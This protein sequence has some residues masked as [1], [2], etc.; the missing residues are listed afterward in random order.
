MKVKQKDMPLVSVGC[1]AY[2]HEA[3][4]AQA[5]EGFLMQKTTFPVEIIVYDDASTD[6]TADI[7][8]DYANRYP[9]IIKPVLQNR[10]QYSEGRKP[11]VDYVFPEC[12]GRYIALCEGDD[13]WTDPYKLQKQAEFME[14]HPDC[15]M[16][17]HPVQITYSDNRMRYWKDLYGENE[18]DFYNIEEILAS[19]SFPEIPTP[20]LML[21][22][23][24]LGGLPEWFWD[25]RR[26]DTALHLLVAGQGK[27]GF[28][29]ECMAVHRKHGHGVS[30]LFEIDADYMQYDILR[31]YM[32]VDQYYDYKYHHLLRRHIRNTISYFLD[33]REVNPEMVE[34]ITDFCRRLPQGWRYW[35]IVSPLALKQKRQSRC[36]YIFNHIHKTAGTTFLLSY[37]ASAFDE[38][39]RFVIPG[40]RPEN[41]RA[42]EGLKQHRKNY[43]IIGGHHAYKLRESYPHARFITLVR[44]PVSRIVSL[45]LHMKFHPGFLDFLK[46]NNI[47]INLEELSIRQIVEGN[48]S[49]LPGTTLSQG[50]NFQSR[51]L[52]YPDPFN[53][54]T[55]FNRYYLVGI[56]ERLDEFIFAL[57]VLDNFPLL[58]FNNRMVRKERENFQLTDEDRELIIEYNQDDILLYREAKSRFDRII[59][60]IKG[61]GFGEL[62]DDYKEA[63]K[64]F[65]QLTGCDEN[66]SMPY[67][68]GDGRAAVLLERGE[69]AFANGDIDRAINMF[70]E[71]VEGNP[72]PLFAGAAYN[73][74]GVV[75]YHMNRIGDAMHYF[76]KSLQMDQNNKNTILN[77][78]EILN[79][80]GKHEDAERLY[81]SFQKGG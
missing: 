29:R 8:K 77:I 9:D 26:G 57:H 1:V 43:L 75:C 4:I 73:N 34:D 16:S 69:E 28:L 54:D 55:L 61:A 68:P 56:S 18:R 80:L 15:V 7:I 19:D 27:L 23:S 71:V 59:E 3:F 76:R 37:V 81:A 6:K 67:M 51:L 21:R 33:K 2:N 35:D 70:T 44:E 42:I 36:T 17:C 31:V 5:L 49:V 53:M 25:V 63:I 72:S 60:E 47:D 38:K 20:G 11:F 12:R 14:A 65:Q 66:R 46:K 78:C 10:N 50:R 74:I 64:G 62:L 48:I 45:Y 32:Y 58:L 22:R 13:Y 24:A 39:D 40:T 41:D 30:R 79:K 52:C